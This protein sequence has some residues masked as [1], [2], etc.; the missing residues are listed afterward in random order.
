MK[1]YRFAHN[2]D[3]SY[4][5][6][7]GRRIRRVKEDNPFGSLSSTGKPFS[8]DDVEILSP[9][10][11]GKIIGVGRNYVAHARELGND[12][13]REP[14]LFL[15][16]PSSV[17]G[18]GDEVFLPASSKRVDYEGEL[19]IVIGTNCRDVEAEDWPEY[20]LGFTCANDVTARDL[21]K[22]DGQF[23]RAKGFD[24]F[25]PLGP[26]IET[27]IDPSD[28]RLRTRRNGA[29]VQEGRTSQMIVE[30]GGLLAFVSG[31]MTL[32]PGDVILTGT[33]AGVGP[34]AD[35][36]RVEIEIE[37][38]GTLTSTVVG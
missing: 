28:L 26:C 33:P 30:V 32:E 5:V 9:I 36:D 34:L 24:T 38:I 25:C 17:V 35:G 37:G 23:T 27:E 22:K 13:P 7:E 14:L 31:V 29:V 10:S 19:A 15:K 1:I 8:F 20:V 16:P 21:Q 6:A 3:V 18:P 11:P 12:V 4:G 2:G